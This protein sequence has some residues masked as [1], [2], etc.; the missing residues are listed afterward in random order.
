MKKATVDEIRARFD[1]HVERY[2]N[3]ETGQPTAIDGGLGLS[4]IVEA[5]ARSTPDAARVLD[6]G[7]GGGNFT[8]RLREKLPLSHATLLDLSLPMLTRARERV[9]ATGT[10]VETRHQDVREAEFPEGSFDII[11]AA[12]VL[13]HLREDA[14]WE[15]VYQSL[16]RWLRPG[17]SLWIFDLVSHEIPA[18]EALQRERYAQFLRASGGEEYAERIL[19]YVD[20]E[21]SPRPLTYQL[22]LMRANGFTHIDV[23]LKNAAF[24]AFGGIRG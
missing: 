8:L 7:C 18:V 13:H 16:S 4:L 17:G 24:A 22:G 5:A 12:A 23:L 1:A 19:A 15:A 2:S 14:E 10:E 21:D 3:L 9:G 11:V 6:V 20:H